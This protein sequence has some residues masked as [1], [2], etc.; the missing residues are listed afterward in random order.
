MDPDVRETAVRVLGDLGDDRA[1]E[2]LIT[3]LKKSH[4]IPLVWVLEAIV[5][6]LGKI[7]DARAVEPPIAKLMDSDPGIREAAVASLDRS[8]MCERSIR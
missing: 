7:G 3:T 8:A 6:A 2:P 1:V 5:R 4:E